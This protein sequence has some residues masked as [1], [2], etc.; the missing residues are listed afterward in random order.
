MLDIEW[1]GRLAY[2]TAWKW[3]KSLV[4]EREQNPA[5]DDKLLLLEHPPT[6]TLGRHGRLENLL[7]NQKTLDDRGFTVHRVDRGGDITYHGPGQLVGYPILNLKRIYGSGIGRIRQYVTDLEATLIHLLKSFSIN[8]QRFAGHRG[9]WV[10][11]DYGMKKIAA[12]GVHVTASGISSHGFALNVNPNME[13]FG[14]IIPCGIQDYGVTCMSEVL[15][16]PLQVEEVYPYV[17]DAFA[18]IMSMEINLESTAY[19]HH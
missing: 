6:Y 14:G 8:G 4:A 11:T 13:H 9:V 1:V 2:A 19:A 7:L 17:I 16:G 18:E 3:Q 12:I 5:L 10:P 15:A